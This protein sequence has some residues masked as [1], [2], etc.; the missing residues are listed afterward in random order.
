LYAEYPPYKIFNN[1]DDVVSVVKY[2]VI[3]VL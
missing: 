2:T 3:I 1:T